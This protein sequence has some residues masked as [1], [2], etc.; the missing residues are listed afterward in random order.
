MKWK[1][2][3]CHFIGHPFTLNESTSYIEELFIQNNDLSVMDF[4]ASFQSWPFLRQ[5]YI[6]IPL[7]LQVVHLL[8]HIIPAAPIL[9]E[10]TLFYIVFD[11]LDKLQSCTT[12]AFDTPSLDL[13]WHLNDCR[14]YPN[15][16]TVLEDIVK[17]EKA[18]LMRIKLTLRRDNCQV[19]QTIMN[20]SLCVGNSD[21]KCPR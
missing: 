19:L 6:D 4:M 20:E 1:V 8:E 14:F 2:H 5:L 13:K 7:E 16:I 11:D 9:Q 15:T 10:L 3:A 12:I 17:S 21:I 18:K